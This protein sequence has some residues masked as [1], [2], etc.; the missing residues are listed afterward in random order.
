MA[1]YFGF[2]RRVLLGQGLVAM[3]SAVFPDRFERFGLP[4][5]VGLHFG[6]GAALAAGSHV[7]VKAE[8]FETG[9]F[10]FRTSAV[11]LEVDQ[12]GFVRVERQS[13]FLE[14]LA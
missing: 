7:V 4:N 14:S 10:R 12:L 9:L 3:V 2:E 13:V 6:H 8:E 5:C 11:S 1:L